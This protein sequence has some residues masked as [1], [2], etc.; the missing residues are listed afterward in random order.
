MLETLG[1]DVRHALRSLRRAPGFTA[2]TIV[3]LALGI[4]ANAAVFS[5]V[6]A[7]LLRRLPVDHPEQLYAVRQFDPQSP[8]DLVERTRSMRFSYQRFIELRSTLPAGTSLAA[9]TPG[10]QFTVID[11]HGATMSARGQLVAGN[12]FNTLGIHTAAGRLLRDEDNAR[13]DAEP[14]VVLAQRFAREHFVT[15]S[16]AVGQTLHVNGQP[17]TVVGVIA[18]SYRGLWVDSVADMWMPAAM[19]HALRYR[20][21]ASNQDGQPEAS[22]VPQD[23]IR[24]LTLVLRTAG[25][26]AQLRDALELANRSGI[27]RQAAREPDPASAARIRASHVALDPVPQGFSSF[28]TENR[29]ALLLVWALVGLVLVIACANVANLLLAR[30]AAQQR[31]LTIRVALGASGRQLL[32]RGLIESALLVGTSAVAG[33]V[34]GQSLARLVANALSERAGD[35]LVQSA[36]PGT[37]VFGVAATMTIAVTL[38]LGAIPGWRAG[39]IET[40]TH[41]SRAITGG[42]AV[43]G[44]RPLLVLQLALSVVVVVAAALLGRSLINLVHVDPGFDREHLVV[45]SFN[46][47]RSGYTSQERPALD[48]RLLAAVDRLPGVISASTSMV[49]LMSGDQW[50][51]SVNV[52]GYG[53]PGQEV[54]VQGNQVGAH[55]FATVGTPVIR[56]REFTDQDTPQS[57]EV[58]VVNEAFAR[59][60]FE[61]G[62]AIGRHLDH[63]VTIVGVVRD[64][65]WRGV[66]QSPAPAVFYPLS[67]SDDAAWGME[68]RVMGDP[69][70]AATMIQQA[71]RRAE[72][73]LA[74][75]RVLPIARP[76]EQNISR[77][78]QVAYLA[79]GFALMAIVLA[80]VGLFG[81]LSY[82]IAQRTSE[83]GVRMAIGAAPRD[84]L[85]SV[86]R[87]S[88]VVTLVGIAIGLVAAAA[89]GRFASSVLFGVDSTDPATYAFV[90]A[91]LMVVALGASYV[92]ARRASH[93]DPIVALRAE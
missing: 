35:A 6:E 63:T 83:I 56:G 59:R 85:T 71:L 39:R 15:A 45:V 47:V 88:G 24:W 22:W 93:I 19:Q 41:T 48:R 38:V 73:Q 37:P 78:A 70:V 5:L 51:T 81:V 13:I 74:L 26:L 75:D 82:V 69:A 25:E 16:D 20:G 1:R 92:P 61:R 40:L 29:R 64:A 32:R 23:D 44:M 10:S 67:Q 31:D 8:D 12:Y 2:T 68:L 89:A 14:V 72:P 65:R 33:L 46:P 36:F 79:S 3:T 90:A 11:R 7:A 76:L 18:D 50:T 54:D 60:Y 4:G 34:A 77:D 55:Y 80:C 62:D 91:M 87:D 17:V 49:G 42:R 52:E 43:A 58:V 9:S 86:M 57:P 30:T 28:R 84:V 66:R 21:P 53:T 27:E